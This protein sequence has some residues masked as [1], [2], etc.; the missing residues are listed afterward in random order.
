MVMV[1]RKTWL[2][3]CTTTLLLW[4]AYQVPGVTSSSE[5]EHEDEENGSLETIWSLSRRSLQVDSGELKKQKPILDSA[6]TEL[7]DEQFS[8]PS[9]L[10]SSRRQ[11]DR[12]RILSPSSSGENEKEMPTMRLWRRSS[13]EELEDYDFDSQLADAREEEDGEEDEEDDDDRAFRGGNKGGKKKKK[14]KKKK[15]GGETSSE[16]VKRL[17][18]RQKYVPQFWLGKQGGAAGLGPTQIGYIIN[19]DANDQSGWKVWPEQWS[20]Q[21]GVDVGDL[22][23]IDGKGWTGKVGAPWRQENHMWGPGF[24]HVKHVEDDEKGKK[25]KKKKKKNKG[26]KGKKKKGKKKKKKKKKQPYDPCEDYLEDDISGMF[27]MGRGKK[28]KKDKK[29]KGKK[30]KKGGGGGKGWGG[31]APDPCQKNGKALVR[32]ATKN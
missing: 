16:E 21:P 1:N 24:G 23:Y 29:D 27:R 19:N 9:I 14:K 5:Q 30:G 3:L 4:I 7:D 17:K 2:I 22:K 31:W 15:K 18:A 6:S 12:F 26:G 32:L 11:L 8:R 20:K 28:D 10:S 25:K 13:Q